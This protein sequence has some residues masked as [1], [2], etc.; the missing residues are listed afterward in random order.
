MFNNIEARSITSVSQIKE[1]AKTVLWQKRL[2]DQIMIRG[3]YD[4]FKIELVKLHQSPE[5]GARVGTTQIGREGV[6]S[7]IK[8]TGGR[9]L[10]GRGHEPFN[11][12]VFFLICSIPTCFTVLYTCVYVYIYMYVYISICICIY[13]ITLYIYIYTYTYSHLHVYACLL[14]YMFV[15]LYVLMCFSVCVQH[16]H[17]YN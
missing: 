16:T 13:N 3:E 8:L 5:C 6:P 2:R 1:Q 4:M 12:C 9:G 15:Y 11:R 7:N 14:V 17:I 10:N